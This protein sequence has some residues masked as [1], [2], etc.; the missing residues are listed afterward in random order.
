M[1]IYSLKHV[2]HVQN[3]RIDIATWQFPHGS[4]ARLNHMKW[5]IRINLHSGITT[6][7][8]CLKG[9][10]LQLARLRNKTRTTKMLKWINPLL[11]TSC[12]DRFVQTMG[13]KFG[14]GTNNGLIPQADTL[15]FFQLK[16]LQHTFRNISKEFKTYSFPT[17]LSP[18]SVEP[19]SSQ[20]LWQKPNVSHT[21]STGRGFISAV[22]EEVKLLPKELIPTKVWRPLE[23]IF[24]SGFS[25]SHQWR[26]WSGKFHRSLI[27][28]LVQEK[29]PAAT[30]QLRGTKNI[31]NL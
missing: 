30:T 27:P 19:N 11:N 20:S 21:K 25:T 10:V 26:G 7:I 4:F 3:A 9:E 28:W 1:W 31:E 16:T 14:F 29:L 18:P 17:K 15:G 23:P 12:L 13:A 5:I 8:Y 22:R 24:K 2:F 6:C